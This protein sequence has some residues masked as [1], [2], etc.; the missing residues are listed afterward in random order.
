MSDRQVYFTAPWDRIP[1]NGPALTGTAFVPDAHH[2]AGRGG[3]VFALWSN[4]QATESNFKPTLLSCLTATLGSPVTPEELFSYIAAIAANPAYTARFQPDLSTPGLRIPLSADSGLFHEAAELGRRVLWLHTFGERM[5]DPTA[6]RPAGPPRVPINPPTIPL[7]GRI[8]PKPEDFPDAL[9]YDAEKLRLLVGHGFIEN[10]PPSVWKY[11]V[12]GKHVLTQW[13][14]YRKLHRERPVIGDRRPPSKLNEIQPDHW[15]PEYT[16]ELLNV[17]NVLALLVQLEPA[18]ADL[19][20]RICAGPLLSHQT[21][22]A[23]NALA[24]PAKPEKLK[25]AKSSGPKLF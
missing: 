4:E 22:V 23:A 16:T 8:S 9:N 12:S 10:V 7:A 2:Y 25:K 20:E 24:I 21:L 5:A 1:S 17:L 18:Q 14:S 3:R 11:E 13:F 6:G 15:L 19:L